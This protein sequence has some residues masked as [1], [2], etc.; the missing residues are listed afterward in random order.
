M[1]QPLKTSILKLKALYNPQILLI[2]LL[3]FASVAGVKAQ[4]A[5]STQAG[6]AILKA[7][8][9]TSKNKLVSAKIRTFFQLRYDGT[10]LVP[11]DNGSIDDPY[12]DGYQLQRGRL[13]VTGHLLRPRLKYHVQYAFETNQLIQAFLRW[14][15][16]KNLWITTGHF[17]PPSTLDRTT[18]PNSLQ[19]VD[20]SVVNAK[21]GGTWDYGIQIGHLWNP[22]GDFTIQESFSIMQG[23]GQTNT[24]E[25]RGREFIGRVEVFPIGHMK[26][27]DAH[28][29]AD[30]QRRER[31]EFMLGGTISYNE[32]ARRQFSQLGPFFAED[33]DLLLY[34]ADVHLKWKGLSFLAEF[35]HRESTTGSP[36]VGVSQINP[37][38]N[39]TFAVGQG[40][41][42]Q[43]GY[44]FPSRW[45]VAGR[46]SQLARERDAEPFQREY[47]TV[48]VSK[49]LAGHNLKV[50]SD[51]TYFDGV[52][53]IDEWVG[54]VQVTF[55]F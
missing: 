21:F 39:Q 38:F 24:G 29:G 50:Q 45:E 16:R 3:V 4:T 23:E 48:A 34:A 8:T 11:E 54:R 18:L 52:G 26:N 37:A 10:L 12:S 20:R 14:N 7:P 53:S 40:Y 25:N 6:L 28:K 1:R 46:Y 13:I 19:F 42:A 30:L 32:K 47:Y 2:T 41:N 36:R 9:W 49:Y 17:L 27:N 31:P 44:V 35:V 33:R 43:M 22:F 15:I 51:I 5:D 55:G